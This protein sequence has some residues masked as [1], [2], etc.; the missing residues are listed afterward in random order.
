MGDR[1][2]NNLVSVKCSSHFIHELHLI[3]IS[4][5]PYFMIGRQMSLVLN[6]FHILL[7][8]KFIT[9]PRMV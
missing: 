3:T 7:W 8:P 9:V 4:V 1:Q 5:I 6:C 2:K